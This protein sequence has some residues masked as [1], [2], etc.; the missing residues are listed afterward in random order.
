METTTMGTQSR[1][2]PPAA[3]VS[4]A[5][6]EAKCDARRHA[7]VTMDVRGAEVHVVAVDARHLPPGDQRRQQQWRLNRASSPPTVVV[8]AALEE[9]RDR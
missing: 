9:E 1:V 2:V 4:P 6:L 5:A 7:T 3:V 8:P